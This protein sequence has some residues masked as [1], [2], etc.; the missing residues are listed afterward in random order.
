MARVKLIGFGEIEYQRFTGDRQA[1]FTLFF[2]AIF[3]IFPFNGIQRPG[4]C[5][6]SSD[7]IY[8]R[9]NRY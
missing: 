7:E 9:S 6:L 4:I 8:Y 5:H 2:N 1:V 3:I